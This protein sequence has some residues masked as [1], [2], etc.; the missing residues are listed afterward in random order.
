MTKRSW[1]IGTILCIISSIFLG[2]YLRV[3]NIKV[4]YQE[5][6]DAV[7]MGNV[8]QVTISQE[9]NI[10]FMLKD[11]IQVYETS[12]PRTENFKEMLLLNGVEVKESSSTMQMLLMQYVFSTIVF[13]GVFFVVFKYARPGQR[14]KLGFGAT[15]V[16]VENLKMDFS[17]IAGNVEAKEQVQDVVDFIQNPDKYNQLGAKMPRG[18]I[19]YGPPGTGKTMMA[20]ALAKEAG[21]PFFSVNGSDFMQMYVGVGASRI[22]ELFKEARKSEKAVI[23]IDEIDAIGKSRSNNVASSNDEKDQTL[24]ALLTE[25]SGFNQGEGIVVIAATN[26]LE[27]L[28]EALLRPGRFDRHIQIGYPDQAARKMIL[29]LYVKDKPLEDSVNIDKLCE[30]TIYFTGAMLENLVNEAAI[31]AVKEESKCITAKHFDKA[32]YT[33]IAGAEKKDRSQITAED[34]KITAFHEAGHALVTTLVSPQNKVSKVTII[35]STKGAGGFSM[36]IPKEK[37]YQ[38]KQDILAQVKIALAGRVAEE[39]IFGEDYV[40]T[41]ASND[42]EKAT[43]YIKD[44]I[45]K[46]GMDDTMGLVNISIFGKGDTDEVIELTK[47][48]MKDMYAETKELLMENAS[49]LTKLAEELIKKE[50]LNSDDIEMLLAA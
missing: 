31:T 11:D 21:V 34:K 1:I 3:D 49:N 5:F 47:S 7:T 33:V 42:I 16:E 22:R 38:T 12:N 48:L 50:T 32:F 35:P 36:N 2:F 10:S 30:D 40:T 27:L 29:S 26:R 46:Y 37:M 41:G 18:L 23:F 17:D 13:V 44:Y 20:K 43:S 19:F 14:D 45:V 6:N 39:I 24:N 4:S 8:E 28:D 15:A 9:E 25:M